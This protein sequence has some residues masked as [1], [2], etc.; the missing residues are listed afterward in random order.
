MRL[1]EQQSSNAQ[2]QVQEHG[3]YHGH[4][5]DNHDASTDN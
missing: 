2:N 5:A 4:A 3:N 1:D